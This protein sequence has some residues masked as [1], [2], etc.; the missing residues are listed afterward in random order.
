MYTV[1]ILLLIGASGSATRQIAT[2]SSTAT[3]VG[4][5]ALGGIKDAWSAGGSSRGNGIDLRFSDFAAPTI[6]V[7]GE[8][9]VG[10]CGLGEAV[11]RVVTYVID[12]RRGGSVGYCYQFTHDEYFIIRCTEIRDGCIMLTTDIYWVEQVSVGQ[13]AIRVPIHI[14]IVIRV[15]DTGTPI[16]TEIAGYATGVA[17]V[18]AF[19]CPLARCI[20]ERQASKILN[21]ELVGA[22]IRIEQTGRGL[23]AAGELP[24]VIGV[25]GTGIRALGVLRR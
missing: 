2:E 20:V 14:Q 17:S 9:R 10:V 13:R 25:V 4:Q 19:R 15:N 11:W 3:I 7:D 1:V 18:S 8:S 16:G 21:R 22:L 5:I 12:W 23:Y 6:T 24:G